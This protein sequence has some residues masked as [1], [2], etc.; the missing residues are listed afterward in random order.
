MG[1][2]KCRCHRL[3][4]G[5][6]HRVETSLNLPSGA[7]PSI[8]ECIGGVEWLALG[9]IMVLGG[10]DPLINQMLN[11]PFGI[12][13]GM[14]GGESLKLLRGHILRPLPQGIILIHPKRPSRARRIG[15]VGR[16]LL[17]R[18]IGLRIPRI[19][20]ITVRH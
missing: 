15:V 20:I 5:L 11:S 19:I 2:L 17:R 18:R 16:F 12:T 14:L 7:K 3:F 9:I 4:P 6:P 1:L 10:R 8:P 13:L